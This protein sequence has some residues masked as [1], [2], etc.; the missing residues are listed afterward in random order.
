MEDVTDPPFRSICKEFGA[1]IVYTE[2]IS[3]EGLV[4]GAS[5]SIKKLSV[6]DEERPVAI[7]IFGNDVH[8]MV[9]AA[10]IAEKANPDFIDINFGCPAKKV[11]GRGAG[12]GLLCTPILLQELATAVVNAVSLPVTAKT[13][14][15]WDDSTISIHDTVKRME[16]AG[17]QALTIH[18]RTRAQMFKG[19]AD[20]S[21]IARAKKAAHIPII[22]NGDIWT[23]DDAR[24]KLTLSNVDALMVGRGSIGNPF[25]FREIKQLFS[26]GTLP[27]PPTPS[28][29]ISVAIQHLT[30]SIQWKGEKYG[31][32]EMRKH[33]S[34]F[35]FFPPKTEDG[36][37]KLF[38]SINELNKLKPS[39]VSITY[40]AGGSTRELTHALVTRIHKEIGLTVVPHLTIVNASKSDTKSILTQYVLHGI[41]NIL[42]LRGDPPK[43]ISKTFIQEFSFAK[44]LVLF[45]KQLFPDICIGVAGF[46]EGHPATPNRIKEIEYLKEKVNAGADYIVTQLFFDNRDFYDFQERCN[47]AGIHVPIIAGIMPITS[48]TSMLKMADLAGGA[49]IPAKLL[50]AVLRMEKNEDVEK[51]GTHWATEQV[52]DL[53]SNSIHG[54]HFYT[55]N[56]AN[57]IIKIYETLSLQ[58]YRNT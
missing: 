27:A 46:P 47:I 50:K 37:E 24:E 54:I 1:D 21:W 3:S 49:R 19:K 40:G 53:I 39:Y 33:Y 25:I 7:Q 42:A 12:S 14:I 17:V 57:A 31:V 23:A 22:G 10:L 45:I 55:L 20:W 34:T 18:G 48:K 30:R 32:L 43:Q 38:H 35:E 58:N 16:D 13:R 4:R 51:V 29:K 41:S 28:E 56:N 36:W 8:A 5:K 26:T 52:Q 11:A 44:D 6:F 15:G 9:E 2:F